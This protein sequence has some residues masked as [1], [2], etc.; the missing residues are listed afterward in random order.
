MSAC[1]YFSECYLFPNLRV[2]ALDDI[3]YIDFP[4]LRFSRREST[5]MPFRYVADDK[6]E[7]ILPNV[8]IQIFF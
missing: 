3:A 7:P 2:A 4:E 8:R 1:N 6:G 5:E